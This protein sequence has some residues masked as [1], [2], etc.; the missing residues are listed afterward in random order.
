MFSKRLALL[1]IVALIALAALPSGASAN[2][3]SVKC[4]STGV[5][6][7]YNANFDRAT[8]STETVNG[9]TQTFTVPAHQAA[10]HTWPAC[11]AR[12][13][14]GAKWNGGSIPTSS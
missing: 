14:V 2:T 9:E 6:F 10:T 5:V 11:P 12:S 4:D 13:I 8:V 3:G 1:P 7:S